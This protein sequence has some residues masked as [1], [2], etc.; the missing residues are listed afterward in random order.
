MEKLSQ[1]NKGIL[2][3]YE[4]GYRIINGKIIGAKGKEIKGGMSDTGYRIFSVKVPNINKSLKV[5]V[6]R[7]VAYQKFGDKIFNPDLVVR[8]LDG[9]PLN[10]LE[11]N[12]ALGTDSDNMMDRKPEDR[13]AH[14]LKAT[15]KNRK[16][17]DAQME[18]IRKDNLNGISYNELMI[19][20]DISS[21]G[22]LS[23][24]INNKYKTKV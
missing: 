12:L 5:N 18:Q 10:N 4:K 9:N 3:A 13:L 23:Y 20:Y 15:V 21:K 11:N 2:L 14:S 1:A 24:I 22:T 17:S 7:M 16:F 6:H 8:H 19:K